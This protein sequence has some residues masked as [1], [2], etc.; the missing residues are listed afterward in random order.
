VSNSV[1]RYETGKQIPNF[2]IVIRI[3]KALSVS[4][5]DLVP[6]DY[7]STCEEDPEKVLEWFYQMDKQDQQA[8]LHQMMAMVMV[9]KAS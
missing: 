9:K 1:Y 6:D 3:A 4:V 2:P 7:I 5:A 8:M